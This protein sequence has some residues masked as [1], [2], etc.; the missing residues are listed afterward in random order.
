MTVG[1]KDSGNKTVNVEAPGPSGHVAA[2]NFSCY[3]A[4]RVYMYV[5]VCVVRKCPQFLGDMVQ[6]GLTVKDW[7]EEA[8]KSVQHTNPLLNK[9]H[10][11]VIC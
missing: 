2:N 3:L 11:F 6:D 8:K 1:L 7:V 9:Q 5:Y 4:G 10:L